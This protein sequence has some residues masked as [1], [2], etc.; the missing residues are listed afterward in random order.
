MTSRTCPICDQM[1]DTAGAARTHALDSHSACHYCG[2]QLAEPTEERLYKHWLAAHPDDLTN[3]DYK[4]AN[5]AVDSVTFS[6]RLSDGGL[7]S[8]VGGLPRRY[9][10]VAGGTA[11]ASG[12]VI[13]GALLTGDDS[14]G[15]PGGTPAAGDDFEY[16]TMGEDH[17]A[18]TITYFGNYKCP[19]C[20]QFGTGFMLD[21]RR[22]Y[23]AT[24]DLAIRYRNLSYID[25]EP[26]LGPDAV[27][28]GRAALAVYENEPE[29]YWDYHDYIYENQGP[30]SEQWATEETLVAFA[31]DVGVSDTSVIRTAIAESR[32]EDVLRAS[33]TAAQ[34]AG[35]PGT[36]ALVIDGAVLNPL[37]D[38]TETRNAIEDAIASG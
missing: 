22:D 29:V 20:A 33:D 14:D 8:A 35:V 31:S 4:R 2:D 38:Q 10:L 3:V 1:F 21:L 9:L 11:A 19:F 15:S 27:T 23:V 6:E 34:D 32:Y 36:P 25:G 30:E 37:S 26:F 7:A 28:A 18:T 5:A 13:G 17:V 12:I 16:P 24:G